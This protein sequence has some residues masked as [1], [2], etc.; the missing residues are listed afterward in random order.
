M[1]VNDTACKDRDMAIAIIKTIAEGMKP[2]TQQN[3]LESV[4]EWLQEKRILDDISSMTPEQRQARILELLTS[5]RNRMSAKER[6]ER[7]AFYFE[8][9]IPAAVKQTDNSGNKA[10]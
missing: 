5:E 4:A 7:A 1:A 3:A 2:G 8:G 6:K 10:Q 9:G